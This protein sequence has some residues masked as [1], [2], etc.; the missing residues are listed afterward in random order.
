VR[1][2]TLEQDL[3][4]RVRGHEGLH[5]TAHVVKPD[6]VDRCHPN[7]PFHTLAR[8]LE[9]PLRLL[10]PLNQGPTRFEE[11]E[12]L[13]RGLERTSGTVEERHVELVLDLLDRLARR[14]LRHAVGGGAARKAPEPD[15]VAVEL[16]A[17]QVHAATISLFIILMLCFLNFW[18]G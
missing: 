8:R 9:I 17:V 18:L 14:G 4:V 5:V 11:R 2:Q 6:R 3:G 10:E 12:A 15:D 16:Q 1:V 7:R 13:R